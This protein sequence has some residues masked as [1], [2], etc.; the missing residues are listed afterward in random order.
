MHRSKILA[1]SIAY[2]AVSAKLVALVTS[3]ATRRTLKPVVFSHDHVEIDETPPKL[4]VLSILPTPYT[5]GKSS[6]SSYP[7]E[8]KIQQF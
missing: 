2:A 5:W 4:Y 8:G 6:S 3:E 7:L 1:A